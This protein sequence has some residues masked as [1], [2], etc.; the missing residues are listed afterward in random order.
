MD[1][2]ILDTIE[3][4]SKIKRPEI[5]IGDTVKLSMK[6]AEGEKERTQVF[7]GIV[8]A[9]KGKGADKTITVRKL[10]YGIGVER[11]VPLNSPTL[12]KVEVIKRG[13]VRRSKLYYMR[14]RIGR[15]AM[16]IRGSEQVYFADEEVKVEE[17]KE[18]VEAKDSKEAVETKEAVVDDKKED[19]MTKEAVEADA[20]KEEVKK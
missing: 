8:I 17:V 19:T 16:K 7:E 4:V 1:K 20:K 11:V 9:L 5:K 10:S 18:D 13:K 3:G 6:I 12:E 2:K 15:L 14:E